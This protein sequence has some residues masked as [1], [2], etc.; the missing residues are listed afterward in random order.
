MRRPKP[1]GPYLPAGVTPAAAALAA[2][3]GPPPAK[4][5]KKKQ[6]DPEE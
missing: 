4:P 2:R 5:T 1:G 6:P 3:Q